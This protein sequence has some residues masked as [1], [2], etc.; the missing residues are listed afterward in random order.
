MHGKPLGSL[1]SPLSHAPQL[2]GPNPVSLLTLL[3]ASPSS[4]AIT[5]GVGSTHW[6]TVWGALIHIWR[7]EITDGG[8][9]SGLLIWQEIF[10]FRSCKVLGMIEHAHMHTTRE[11]SD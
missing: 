8:D 4:S 7:P 3:L 6:I 2:P 10:P 5:T 9:I 1:S 11:D